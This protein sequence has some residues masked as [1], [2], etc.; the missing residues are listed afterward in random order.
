MELLLVDKWSSG[1]ATRSTEQGIFSIVL[2]LLI[3]IVKINSELQYQKIII[4]IIVIIG[5]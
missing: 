5:T 4:I 2:I 1:V 3:I